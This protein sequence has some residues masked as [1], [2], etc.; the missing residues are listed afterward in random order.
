LCFTYVMISASTLP[1]LLSDA[2]TCA[3][4]FSLCVGVMGHKLG[5]AKATFDADLAAAL[6]AKDVPPFTA[7]VDEALDEREFNFSH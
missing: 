1:G 5:A 4:L 2:P 3:A 7:R 6:A